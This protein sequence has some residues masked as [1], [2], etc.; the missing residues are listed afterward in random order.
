[1][2]ASILI[3][4][5]LLFGFGTVS[6]AVVSDTGLTA[7]EYEDSTDCFWD[8]EV[9]GNGSGDSFVDI[10]GTAYYECDTEDAAN[11]FWDATDKGNGEGRS[12]TDVNGVA[13][14]WDEVG[15]AEGAWATWDALGYSLT[16]TEGGKVVYLTEGQA[17]ISTE[18]VI[19]VGEYLFTVR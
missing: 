11:C 15:T 7:C 18:P 16:L 1:M 4:L 10:A 13:L 19:E 2:I 12:F 5:S 6:Q 9:R 14:Y 3:S 17:Q 8:A